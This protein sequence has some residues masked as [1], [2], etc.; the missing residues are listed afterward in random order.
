MSLIQENKYGAYVAQVNQVYV[1]AR[2]SGLG[3]NAKALFRVLLLELIKH[4]MQGSAGYFDGAI[5]RCRHFIDQENGSGNAER[6]EEEHG[7]HRQITR[8]EEGIEKG[9]KSD[10][11]N[12][13]D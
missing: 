3:T 12:G 13:N 8:G 4:Q 5:Q 2:P 7:D 1:V 6:T 11:N 10:P 9:K